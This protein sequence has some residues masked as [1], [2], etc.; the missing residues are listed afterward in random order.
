MLGPWDDLEERF[1][2]TGGDAVSDVAVQTRR[3]SSALANALAA[4]ILGAEHNP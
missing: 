3:F 2:M 4:A 1:V